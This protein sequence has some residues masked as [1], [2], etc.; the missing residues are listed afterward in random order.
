MFKKYF[1]LIYDFLFERNNFRIQKRGS[2]FSLKTDG[3]SAF[4][5]KLPNKTM[6]DPNEIGMLAI[7]FF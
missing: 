5:F 4:C 7:V 1:Q 2:K 6:L 3:L